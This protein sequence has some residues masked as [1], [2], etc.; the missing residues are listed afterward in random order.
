ME[1]K[2]LWINARLLAGGPAKP[3]GFVLTRGERIAALGQGVPKG[4][5]AAVRDARGRYLAPG[6]IDGHVHGGGGFDFM[7]GSEEAFRRIAAYHA[8]HGVTALLA[9]TLAGGREETRRV[10][11]AAAAFAAAMAA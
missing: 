4:V 7:D 2:T 6:F 3:D 1:D 8:R 9:T 10:A 5:D 11:E